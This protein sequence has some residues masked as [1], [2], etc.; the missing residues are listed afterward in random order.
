MNWTNPRTRKTLIGI[1]AV[2][3]LVWLCSY[4]EDVLTRVPV[5]QAYVEKLKSAKHYRSEAPSTLT[6][7]KAFG[8][9]IGFRAGLLYAIGMEFRDVHGCAS[10]NPEQVF[11]ALAQY[12]YGEIIWS[13]SWTNFPVKLNAPDFSSKIA[14]KFFTFHNSRFSFRVSGIPSRHQ[15]VSA[16]LDAIEAS[17]GCLIK[18]G[19]N[20]YL[21]AKVMERKQYEAAIR[22]L[23][24][25]DGKQ[26]PWEA[27]N[28]QH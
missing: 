7:A 1:A 18:A 16:M 6:M 2:A 5:D 9:A 12:R 27:Q 10:G 28:S 13:D 14:W 15:A 23:G 20:R 21:V 4:L 26:P 17:G 25:L 22:Y 8:K 3:V 11:T 19:K 24:W